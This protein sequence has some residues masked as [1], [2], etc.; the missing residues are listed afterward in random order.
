M[1]LVKRDIKEENKSEGGERECSSPSQI[2]KESDGITGHFLK[3]TVR[4]G[5]QRCSKLG[6]KCEGGKQGQ[7]ALK[8]FIL[9]INKR[10]TPR[11]AGPGGRNGKMN[12]DRARE[13][14]T[15]TP[16]EGE[17]RPTAFIYVR[18]ENTKNGIKSL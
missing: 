10:Q 17:F 7:T 14:I 9:L 13:A 3:E 6:K 16:Q 18:R 1:L 4:E 11:S 8:T 12:T 15:V 2:S 5:V